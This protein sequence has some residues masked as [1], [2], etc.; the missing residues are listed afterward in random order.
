ML[1]PMALGRKAIMKDTRKFIPSTVTV[2]V[3]Q[4]T[5]G[6][7]DMYAIQSEAETIGSLLSP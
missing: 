7:I 5:I 4:F 3:F 2:D 6:R 1:M